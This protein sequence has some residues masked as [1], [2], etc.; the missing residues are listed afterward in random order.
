MKQKF[1]H[2][3]FIPGCLKAQIRSKIACLLSRSSRESGNQALAGQ[4]CHSY[5]GFRGV[6]LHLRRVL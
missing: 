6:G 4:K 2:F 1:I 5:S 3:F